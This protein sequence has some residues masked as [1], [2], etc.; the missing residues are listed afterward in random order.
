MHTIEKKNSIQLKE[1]SYS[2]SEDFFF[3]A[4]NKIIELINQS[5]DESIT[6]IVL[7]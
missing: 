6:L 3:C 1:N 4:I 2:F 7:C 5:D